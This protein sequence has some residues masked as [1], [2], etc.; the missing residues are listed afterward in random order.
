MKFSSKK[1]FMQSLLLLFFFILFL[2]SCFN[3][4]KIVNNNIFVILTFIING[5]Y[6][7]VSVLKD[8]SNYSLNKTFWY[9]N[10]FFFFLAPLFQYITG[11]Y[12]WKY[13]IADSYFIKGNI[14]ILIWLIMYRVMYNALLKRKMRK[15][16]KKIVNKKYKFLEV[17]LNSNILLFLFILSIL[18]LTYMI[19][20]VSFMGLFSRA[21][22]N[23]S[24]DSGAINTI[25]TNLCRSIP[26]FSTLYAYL[27]VKE[28]KKNYL[29]FVLLL[30][31]NL[32]INFPLSITRYWIGI[33]YIGLFLTIFNK[34][35]QGK[36]FDYLMVLIFAILF[37]FFQLFKWYG[38]DVFTNFTTI[39]NKFV[40]SYN[41][42]DFDAYSMFLR[43]LIYVES[44]AFTLGHQ[45]LSSIFFYVPRS[46]WESKP[47]PT[48]QYVATLQNQIYTN[49]SF[50][51]VAEGYIEF[52]MISVFIYTF[53]LS[54]I[55]SSLDFNFH[56]RRGN[57]DYINFIFPFS[58]G[59]LIFLLRGA[60]QPVVVYTFSFYL[61][62]ILIK[63]FITKKVH[64]DENTNI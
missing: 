17:K 51:F 33:I 37:P 60:L 30:L 12:P 42:V 43:C 58:L 29:V 8:N 2:Y 31:I 57:K 23:L 27:Y 32:I 53:F 7:I 20:N 24:F 49:V 54:W 44:H 46:V 47:Y 36:R 59:A 64:I 63:K 34:K 55:L 61:F 11:Y 28:N 25:V 15:V 35:F 5:I 38:I 4:V 39:A 40:S 48:G 21:T 3:G 16:N 26:V 22:N 50:P 41:S 56:N 9:F 62:L 19:Y 10:F 14:L 45:I 1:Q 52:G 18:S 13:Y 6:I